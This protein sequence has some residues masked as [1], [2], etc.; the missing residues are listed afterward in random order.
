MSS[1]DSAFNEAFATART[2]YRAGDL[3]AAFSLLERAHLLGQRQL[4]RH[5][6]VHV[7]MLRIGWRRG[8]LGEVAGQ[9]LRLVLTPLG[10]LTGR[11]PVGNTGG[12]NVSAFASLPVPP[13]LQTLLTEEDK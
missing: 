8:D 6:A 7:W 2:L 4:G 9:L 3:Q 12:S 13:D 1:R 11:L 5:W 10:H